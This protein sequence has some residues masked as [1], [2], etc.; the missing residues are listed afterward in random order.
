ML[1]T[2]KVNI[3]V[4]DLEIRMPINVIYRNML[5]MD[6]HSKFY[7]SFYLQCFEWHWTK[8]NGTGI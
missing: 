3:Y 7:L 2:P 4:A 6:S 1:F 8:G 5:F